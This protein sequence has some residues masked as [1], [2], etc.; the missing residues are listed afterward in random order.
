MRIA[1]RSLT[2]PCSKDHGNRPCCL[3][4]V[5]SRSRRTTHLL[6]CWFGST[7]Q[8]AGQQATHPAI[9]QAYRRGTS[10]SLSE[11]SYGLMLYDLRSLASAP[12]QSWSPMQNRHLQAHHEK[13]HQLGQRRVPQ[14]LGH[15]PALRRSAQNEQAPGVSKQ[16]WLG[17]RPL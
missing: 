7:V 3:T 10:L 16:L 17:S 14:H 4:S 9:Q 15:Q 5:V 13:R 11:V 12:A 2:F 1:E 6:L 8:Q